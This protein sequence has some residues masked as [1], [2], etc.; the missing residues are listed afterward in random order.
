MLYIIYNAIYNVIYIMS[1]FIINLLIV[2]L[3]TLSLKI[4]ERCWTAWFEF[5]G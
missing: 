3:F 4:E 1:K 2:V 5:F